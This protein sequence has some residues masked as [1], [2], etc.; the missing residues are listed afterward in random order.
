MSMTIDVQTACPFQLAKRERDNSGF[1]L[2]ALR[3][4]GIANAVRGC[5]MR[6][7]LLPA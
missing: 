5:Q 3:F 1:P 2:P 7:A 6:G 4:S